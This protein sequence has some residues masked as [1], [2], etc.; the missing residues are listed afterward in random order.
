MS[1]LLSA[2]RGVLLT[3]DL[4]MQSHDDAFIGTLNAST[5]TELFAS[6]LRLAGNLGVTVEFRELPVEER[7]IGGLQMVSSAV[8]FELQKRSLW[9]LIVDNLSSEVQGKLLCI[10]IHIRMLTDCGQ[11]K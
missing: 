11:I 8:K 5:K 3:D 7:L 4:F 10:H 9:L 6:Y 2:L 1:L